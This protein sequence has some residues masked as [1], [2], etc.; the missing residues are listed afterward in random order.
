VAVNGIKAHLLLAL[1]VLVASALPFV[2]TGEMVSG[3]AAFAAHSELNLILIFVT[4]WLCSVLG[5]TVML[6][7]AR[8]GRRRLQAWLDRH[9]FGARVNAAQDALTRNAFNAVVTGRLIPG[10]RTPVI[11]ALGLSRFPVRRFVL[12]DAV[13]CA[14]WAGI[15]ATL[16]AIGGRVAHHPVWA[17]VVAIAFAVSVGLLVTQLHRLWGWYRDRRTAR[18]A[19]RPL[20]TPVGEEGPDPDPERHGA[21]PVEEHS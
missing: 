18:R 20:P 2:P 4:T 10:G 17:M 13:A 1:S 21:H 15:Y 3:A 5:D 11:V 9:S 7:E 16:G 14:L 12:M 19:A 6:L 8:W